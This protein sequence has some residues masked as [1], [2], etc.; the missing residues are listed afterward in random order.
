MN[1]SNTIESILFFKGEPLSI[2]ELAKLS[3]ASPE[4]VRNALTTLGES[5]TGRGVV[6]V[7]TDDEV[8]LRT[9]P[10]SAELI[11]QL[12]KDELEK[13]IGKAGLETLAV[14]L[15]Q[16]PVTRAHIDHVRGVNSAFIVRNLMI[17]GLIER[18]DNPHDQRSFLY[19]PTLELLSFLGVP[20]REA[21][22]DWEHVRNALGALD[23]VP[24]ENDTPNATTT[25][26]TTTGGAE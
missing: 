3:G 15:Y 14:V 11:E 6:L 24:I 8:A 16:G 20:S 13:D 4:E 19:K 25:A 1:L 18:V 17:R 21:L 7:Q 22:P 2:K 12:R 9:A 26:D 10:E 23:A 5:L